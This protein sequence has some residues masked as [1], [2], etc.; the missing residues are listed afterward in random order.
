MKLRLLTILFFTCFYFPLFSAPVLQNLAMPDTGNMLPEYLP[1]ISA[2]AKRINPQLPAQVAENSGLILWRNKLW[3]HNDSGGE[4]EIYAIDT[5]TGLMVQTISLP[6]AENQDWEDISQDQD[7]I[8]LADVG[9]NRGTRKNL[10]VYKVAKNKIPH[11]GDTQISGIGTIRFSYADQIDF[12]KRMNNHN[13]DCEAIASYGD[14]IYLFTKNWENQRTKM[15][16]IPK[17][18]GEYKISPLADFDAGGL[19]T[20]AEFS[21]DGSQLALLGYAD[22]VS[23]MW[24]F[25]DYEGKNF[26]EA[27]KLRI[28]FPDL[29]F[30]QTEGLCFTTEQ[31]IVFS[32]EESA[33]P[34]MRFRVNTD[35][36]KSIAFSHLG[37]Y[38]ANKIQISGIPPTTSESIHLDILELPEANFSFE[39]RDRRWNKLIEGSGKKKRLQRKVKLEIK[40][41][42]LENGLYFLKISSGEHSIIKKIKIAH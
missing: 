16:A 26:F 28:D 37:D 6:Q 32:C 20:A 10:I 23:F 33:V 25:W 7:F 1:V 2:Q 17:I 4:A 8:Y 34:P 22:Y 5:N 39:L 41:A 15:Y 21:P 9:N 40:T 35:S 13:F 24:L 38:T 12:E 11:S 27:K 42:D 19:I 3:T 14:S 30:V 18:A 36:L 31:D 29:V